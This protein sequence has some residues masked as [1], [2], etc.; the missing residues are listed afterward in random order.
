MALTA[1]LL[2]VLPGNAKAYE[3]NGLEAELFEEIRDMVG[4]LD[5]AVRQ[6]DK[7][8]VRQIDRSLD[9]MIRKLEEVERRRHHRHHK[10]A[11]HKGTQVG[12]EIRSLERALEASIGDWTRF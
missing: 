3:R 12:K 7:K 5:Q 6:G 9:R 8:E 10:G 4:L 2:L 11:F 1:G